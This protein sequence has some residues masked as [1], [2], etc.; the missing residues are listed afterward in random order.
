M[1][2]KL[3]IDDVFDRTKKY[4]NT[5]GFNESLLRERAHTVKGLSLMYPETPVA[6]LE[7]AWNCWKLMPKD[8][9]DALVAS[10]EMEKPSEKV[11]EPVIKNGLHIESSN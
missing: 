11:Y 2:S 8:E 4:H 3:S 1:D 7:T 9:I 5:C 10:K 6:F